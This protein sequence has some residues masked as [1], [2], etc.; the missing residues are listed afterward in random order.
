MRRFVAST[1]GDLDFVTAI[2]QDL[3]SGRLGIQ[4][5]VGDDDDLKNRVAV[6]FGQHQGIHVAYLSRQ[7]IETLDGEILG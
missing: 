2:I 1:G 5:N 4:V 3:Q 7:S 6:A